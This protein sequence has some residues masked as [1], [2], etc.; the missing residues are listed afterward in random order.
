MT[1]WITYPARRASRVLDRVQR[2][3]RTARPG[4][5]LILVIALLVLMALI[6]TAFIATTRTDRYSAHTNVLN[7]QIDLL[8]ESVVR[9]TEGYI[10]GD[11]TSGGGH[12]AAHADNALPGAGYE[13]FDSP[14]V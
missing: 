4:S 10:T 6:G 3:Y 2:R 5:V 13:H 7:T 12:R 11:L 9:F 8:M 14:K 1:H